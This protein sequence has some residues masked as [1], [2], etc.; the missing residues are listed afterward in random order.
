MAAGRARRSHQRQHEAPLNIHPPTNSSNAQRTVGCLMALS[1]LGPRE[2]RDTPRPGMPMLWRVLKPLE[3]RGS[4][5]PRRPRK[6][7]VLGW[8]CGVWVGVAE[9]VGVSGVRGWAG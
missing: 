4:S 6:A 1:K 7:M 8:C 2:V 9:W 5:V 3:E